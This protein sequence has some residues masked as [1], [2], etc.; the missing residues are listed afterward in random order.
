MSRTLLNQNFVCFHAPDN[1][2]NFPQCSPIT[3]RVSCSSWVSI[4]KAI[5]DR[6]SKGLHFFEDDY[7]IERLWNTPNKY[8]P[9][10]SRFDYVIQTDFSLFFDFPVAL[11]IFNKFRNHW[12][13]NFYALYGIQ[14]IPNIRPSLPD[15]WSWSFE[16]YP[17]NS[18]VAFS[19]IGVTKDKKLHQ[20]IIRSYDEMIKRLS[21]IQILYFT[22][23]IS[24]APSECDV[25]ILPYLKGGE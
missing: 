20:I 19:D 2:Y 6:K 15:F 17:K 3:E 8:I 10:L 21:P 16:G 9:L 13:L 1:Y 11:Q 14:M 5:Q 7:K 23:S 22:R 24:S 12:L 4:D 25:I 18:V